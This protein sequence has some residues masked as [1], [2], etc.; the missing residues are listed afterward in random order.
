MPWVYTI[1]IYGIG[2]VKCESITQTLKI[3]EALDSALLKIPRSTRKESYPRFS[4]MS[5]VV[6]DG[7][8]TETSYWII[9]G[10]QVQVSALGQD[11]RYDHILS[12]M[13]PTKMLEKYPVG[14][15]TFT[16]PLGGTKYTLKGVLDRILALS[17]FVIAD[18]IATTRVCTVDSTLDDYLDTITAPQMFL[19]KKNLREALIEVFKYI[20]AIPRIRFTGLGQS[21]VLDADFVN[22]YHTRITPSGEEIEELTAIDYKSEITG[23]YYGTQIESYQENVIPSEDNDTPTVHAVPLS[24]CV[25]FRADEMIISTSN[26]KLILPYKI[27]ILTKITMLATTKAVPDTVSEIDMSPYC[28]EK[29]VYDTFETD[30][31]VGSKSHAFYWQKGSNEL[32]GFNV[33]YGALGITM[34]IDNIIADEGINIAWHKIVFKVEYIPF[35]EQIRSEQYRE[36]LSGQPIETTFQVNPSERLNNIYRTTMNLWGQIQRLGVDTISFSKK[37]KTLHAYDGTHL[38]G[39]Y[40]LGDYT[41]DGYM[42]TAVEKV[43][44]NSFVIVRYELSKNFNR[45]AQFIAVDKEFRPYEVSLAKSDYTLRRNILMRFAYVE[46]SNASATNYI[47]GDLATR[48]METFN[49]SSHLLPVSCATLQ[50]GYL[51]GGNVLFYD[52]GVVMP[53][54]AHAEKNALKFHLAFNNP[55]LAGD[56]AIITAVVGS[57]KKKQIAYTQ[58]NGTIEYVRLAIFDELWDWVSPTA[59]KDMGALVG[60]AQI[61]PYYKYSNT[62]VCAFSGKQLAALIYPNTSSFP[63][64]GDP[65]IYYVAED[66]MA[67]YTWETDHY[68]FYEYVS[69]LANDPLYTLPNYK[70]LKDSSEIL[71]LEMSLPIVPKPSLSNAFIIGDSLAKENALVK[72]LETGR[73]LYFY[74]STARFTKADSLKMPS[75]ATKSTEITSYIS[76]NHITVPTAIYLAYDYFGIGDNDGNLYLGVNQR[77]LDGVKTTISTIY[78]NFLKERTV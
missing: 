32:N 8:N 78:F 25:T 21:W 18:D 63:A 43:Y 56:Q 44:F 48:F 77:G 69:A 9:Y 76:G 34:A 72:V 75:T 47:T 71:T 42:V 4:E 45:V 49:A 52:E 70:I 30:N 51:S 68:Y 5:I 36:D 33:T 11:T 26:M 1:T 22:G 20:N 35:I 13:E 54:S 57:W 31:G 17:P 23:E 12:L 15:L 62:A 60:V 58:S 65:D 55:K 38:T 6:S 39:I 64:K 73:A 14:S 28:F 61:K 67:A 40:S 59:S 16:Q 46:V 7:T 29:A 27:E 37:H 53:V 3:D 41:N 2:T 50:N 24:E 19:D 10:D 66:V 74:Y